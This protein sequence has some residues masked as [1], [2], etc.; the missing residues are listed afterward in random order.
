MSQLSLFKSLLGS[1][2]S[3]SDEVLQYY[4]DCAGDII[5]DLRNSNIVETKYLNVQTQIAIELY[6]KRGAEGEVGHGENGIS[7]SYEKADVSDSLLSKITPMIKTPFS[8]VRVI[9]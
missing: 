5:C 7:R 6:N 3:E 9:E 1:T 2:P 4:L 8:S